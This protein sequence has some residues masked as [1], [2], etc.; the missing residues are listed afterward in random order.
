MK[1]TLN[2]KGKGVIAFIVCVICWISFIIALLMVFTSCTPSHQFT[3]VQNFHSNKP[4]SAKYIA[5][6]TITLI[7]HYKWKHRKII[8]VQDMKKVNGLWQP[9][10]C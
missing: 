3:T 8:A 2:N 6:D 10:G 5:P 9:Y 7:H 1:I 4:I